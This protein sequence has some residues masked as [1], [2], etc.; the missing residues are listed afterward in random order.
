MYWC[1][2]NRFVLAIKTV[3]WMISSVMANLAAIHYNDP[4]EMLQFPRR[5]S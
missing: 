4:D 5:K 3:T 1:V 2:K